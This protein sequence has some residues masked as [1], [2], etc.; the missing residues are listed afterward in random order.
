VNG[1]VFAPAGFAGPARKTCPGIRMTPGRTNRDQ[2]DRFN[3]WPP[4][5][6]LRTV[7]GT[8]RAA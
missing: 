8:D 2:Q 6:W 3:A 4:G 5:R 1:L 7:D